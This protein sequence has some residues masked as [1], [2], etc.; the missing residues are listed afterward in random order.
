[1]LPAKDS[2]CVLETLPDSFSPFN[3]L[4]IV[5][6]LL[7]I[8]TTPL[9]QASEATLEIVYQCPGCECVLPMSSDARAE[10]DIVVDGRLYLC[11]VVGEV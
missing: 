7:V 6:Q 8:E 10:M 1:M 5:C 4:S 3:C 11:T 9:P 2:P